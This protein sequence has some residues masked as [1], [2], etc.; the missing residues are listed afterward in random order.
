MISFTENQDT[1][2]QVV[3]SLLEDKKPISP[4]ALS[5]PLQPPPTSSTSWH[6]CR[7]LIYV[8]RSAAKGQFNGHWP[9]PE[10][11]WPDANSPTLV[12][13]RRMLM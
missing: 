11:F 2:K 6:N 5:Q 8:P 4:L 10:G 7:R 1:N 3:D 13:A 12:S 9:I